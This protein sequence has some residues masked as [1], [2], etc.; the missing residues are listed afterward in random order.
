M[1]KYGKEQSRLECRQRSRQEAGPPRKQPL[2]LT[3]TMAEP[4]Q[5]ST[6]PPDESSL[7]ELSF[8]TPGAFKSWK[9]SEDE[10]ALLI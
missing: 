5:F 8:Q 3:V 1:E 2:A 4:L 10:L 6:T 9:A 7:Q